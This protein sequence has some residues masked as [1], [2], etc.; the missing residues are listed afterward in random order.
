VRTIYSNYNFY[1]NYITSIMDLTQLSSVNNSFV[2]ERLYNY[3]GVKFTLSTGL[4]LVIKAVN[5]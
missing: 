2:Y 1:L 5:N 4:A 3:F